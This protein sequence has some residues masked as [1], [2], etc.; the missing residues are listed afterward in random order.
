V[1]I[2]YLHI[3]GIAV[4]PTKAYTPLIVNSY[5]VSAVAITAELLQMVL[6]WDTKLSQL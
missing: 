2:G 6:G 4:N 1:I 5:A 3:V